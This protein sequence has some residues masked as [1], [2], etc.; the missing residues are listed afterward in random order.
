MDMAI[1][2]LWSLFFPID[3]DFL[4][5]DNMMLVFNSSSSDKSCFEIGIAEDSIVENTEMFQLQLS[6]ENPAVII[7]IPTVIV[8]IEDNDGE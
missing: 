3:T 5:V 2:F 7:S 1:A 4:S 6:S 8:N